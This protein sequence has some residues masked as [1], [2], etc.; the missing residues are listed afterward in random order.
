MSA[1]GS[2]PGPPLD[3]DSSA[4]SGY[5]PDTEAECARKQVGACGRAASGYGASSRRRRRRLTPGAAGQRKAQ[6]RP[7]SAVSGLEYRAPVR[8]AAPRASIGRRIGAQRR[9]AGGRGASLREGCYLR[10]PLSDASGQRDL[11]RAARRGDS[12]RGWLELTSDGGV[13]AAGCAGSPGH[14]RRRQRR[15]EPGGGQQHV[16]RRPQ[17]HLPAAQ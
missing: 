7:V 16:H 15:R 3:S 12:C 13:C 8:V 6:S 1:D 9:L 5:D 17:R 14:E 2:Q 10:A 11:A 4:R